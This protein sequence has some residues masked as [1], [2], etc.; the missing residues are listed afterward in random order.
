VQFWI[1]AGFLEAD[2]LIPVARA[3]EAL[4]YAGI[5]LP[6][7]LYLPERFDS[8][9]PYSADGAVTWPPDAP[10]PDCWV[11]IGAMAAATER[12]RFG[13]SV[14]IGP[15]RDTLSL[16]KAVGTCAAL[17]PGRVM[18]GL[19]AGWLREEFDV[20]GQDFETRGKRLDEMIDTL[21]T[22]WSGDVVESDG[23]HVA[24]PALRMR[25]P[26]GAVPILVGGNTTPALRRAARADGWIAAFTG[27]DELATMLAEFDAQRERQGRGDRPR[28]V[29]VTATPG[30]AKHTDRLTELGVDGVVIPAVTLSESTATGDVIAGLERYAARWP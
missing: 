24:F 28:E 29:L 1:N 20:V 13:T 9:Y 30:I 23:D 10:W 8:A 27:L 16:A 6:D 3:A 11:A 25:P 7:H 2:Q 14:Y 21:P 5:T 18:C 4:G 15:L 17:A 19:G 22:L 26:A 12:L